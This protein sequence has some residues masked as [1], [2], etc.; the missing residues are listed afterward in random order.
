MQTYSPTHIHVDTVF[1]VYLGGYYVYATA[2]ADQLDFLTLD[3][4][5]TCNAM[6]TVCE[7]YCTHFVNFGLVTD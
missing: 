3:S 4:R 7:P 5:V 6:F 2:Y 1:T